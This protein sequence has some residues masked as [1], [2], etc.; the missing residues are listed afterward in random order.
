MGDQPARTK[1][2]VTSPC[3]L[4]T[5]TPPCSAAT[6]LARPAASWSTAC[7][8]SPR[9]T[10]TRSAYSTLLYPLYIF[11]ASN[12]HPCTAADQL[13]DQQRAVARRK[14]SRTAYGGLCQIER[15]DGGRECMSNGQRRTRQASR[16]LSS[17]GCLTARR[18]H[19]RPLLPFACRWV[20]RIYIHANTLT[21]TTTTTL[22][23]ELS[24]DAGA[25]FSKETSTP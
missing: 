15:G 3:T 23:G 4:V 24:P 12:I 7:H 8:N 20:R 25:P 18:S 11:H 2:T 17:P 22:V 10:T 6:G 13:R 19:L 5:V 14:A 21:T 9:S 1:V 16:A